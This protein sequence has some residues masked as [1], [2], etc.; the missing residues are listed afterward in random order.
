MTVETR[1]GAHRSALEV[2]GE[3]ERE[4]GARQELSERLIAALEEQRLPVPSRPQLPSVER[5]RAVARKLWAAAGPPLGWLLLGA[6]LSTLVM[7]GV[8]EFRREGWVGAQRRE[9]GGD[10]AQMQPSATAA[11]ATPEGGTPAPTRP[12]A[13]RGGWVDQHQVRSALIVALGGV[14]IGSLCLG[15]CNH[16]DPIHRWHDGA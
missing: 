1:F 12:G 8:T 6:V 14:S 2:R 15:V 5:C 4:R 7:W 10:A 16:C 11:T 3:L 9:P 13:R